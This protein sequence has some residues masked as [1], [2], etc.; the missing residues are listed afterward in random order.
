MNVFTAP[1]WVS[2]FHGAQLKNIVTNLTTTK[3]QAPLPRKKQVAVAS[4]AV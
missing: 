1:L 4:A 2:S 3:P